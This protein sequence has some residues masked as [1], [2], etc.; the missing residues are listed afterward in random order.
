MP[1]PIG[2]P[3]PKIAYAFSTVLTPLSF[4]AYCNATDYFV[5]PM[6]C[7]ITPTRCWSSTNSKR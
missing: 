5:S 4:S 1:V 7:S 6:C 2:D 3:Q